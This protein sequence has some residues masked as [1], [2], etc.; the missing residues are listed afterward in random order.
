[1]VQCSFSFLILRGRRTRTKKTNQKS[2]DIPT[3]LHYFNSFL[4]RFLFKLKNFINKI[5]KINFN[6]RT[7]NF[8]S[9]RHDGMHIA[10]ILI[11]CYPFLPISGLDHLNLAKSSYQNLKLNIKNV[12]RQIFNL[13]KINKTVLTNVFRYMLL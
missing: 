1:M 3:F 7:R 6:L 9:Y 12:L 8:N 5:S 11:F 2:R 13:F 4:T 10:I